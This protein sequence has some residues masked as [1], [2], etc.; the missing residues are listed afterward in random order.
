[1][2]NML[3]GAIKL[4][5]DEEYVQVN[6]MSSSSSVQQDYDKGWRQQ[7]KDTYVS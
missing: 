5:E 2:K 1:M 4:K 6:D 7:N 3:V